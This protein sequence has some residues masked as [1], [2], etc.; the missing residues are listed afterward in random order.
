MAKPA[1]FLRDTDD[2][3]IVRRDEDPM[4]EDEEAVGGLSGVAPAA[5]GC[6]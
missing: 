6:R 3:L 5:K 1:G 2:F 4:D